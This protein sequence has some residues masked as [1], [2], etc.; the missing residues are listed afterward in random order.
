M[1]LEIIDYSSKYDDCMKDL[2]V[3]L[4]EHIAKIDEEKY[5]IVTK[6]YREKYFEKTMQEVKKYEGKIFLAQENNRI[7]G[8]IIGVINNEAE[9]TYDFRAPKRGR[10]I[11]L[12]VSRKCRSHGIGKALLEHMEKYF[13]TVGCK[14]ILIDVFAY[15][16]RARAFYL[17][18]GYFN[19][20]IEMMKKI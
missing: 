6:E 11:E 5:N 17:K 8:L 15:N 12:V 9:I 13:K 1:V 4:Q 20:S 2:L 10:V 18:N 3:E 16:E 14:G 19:R 7:V